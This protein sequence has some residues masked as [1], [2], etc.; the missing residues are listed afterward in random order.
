MAPAHLRHY[1]NIGIFNI[2]YQLISDHKTKTLDRGWLPDIR[3][4]VKASRCLFKAKRFSD[5]F[6]IFAKVSLLQ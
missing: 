3:L 6:I 2:Y 4:S 1:M 5:Q